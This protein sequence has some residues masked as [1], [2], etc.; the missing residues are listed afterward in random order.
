MSALDSIKPGDVI[1]FVP[2]GGRNRVTVNVE[3]VYPPNIL[4]GYRASFRDDGVNVCVRG[5]CLGYVVSSNAEIEVL[6][7]ATA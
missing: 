2:T 6:R 1:R 3:R 4:M 5:K 7:D